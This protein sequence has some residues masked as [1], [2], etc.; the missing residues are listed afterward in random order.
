MIKNLLSIYKINLKDVDYIACSTGPGSFTGIRV[1]VATAKSFGHAL[2]KKLISVPTLDAL[3]Y[4]ICNDNKIIIPIID[5][6]RN[7]VYNAFYTYNN[8]KLNKLTHYSS[9]DIVDLMNNLSNY[10]KKAVFCGDGVLIHEDIILKNGHTLAPSNLRLTKASSVGTLAFNILEEKG[11][12]QYSEITP[13][14]LKITQAEREY[15]EKI[16]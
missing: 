3:A 5:A 13:F 14:Y 6:R 2:N 15:R 11:T 1:G 16:K 9:D 7:Q 8:K 12:M 4:N 10:D